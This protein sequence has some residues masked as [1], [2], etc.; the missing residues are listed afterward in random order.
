MK[1]MQFGQIIEVD[2]VK[3]EVMDVG[4][5]VIRCLSSRGEYRVFEL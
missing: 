2:G 5:G 4:H 3:Y 1:K